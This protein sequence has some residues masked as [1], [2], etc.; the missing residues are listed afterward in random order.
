MEQLSNQVVVEKVADGATSAGTDVN[1]TAVDLQGYDGVMFFAGIATANAGNFLK[2]QEG[3]TTS[4]TADLAGSKTIAAQNGHIVLVDVYRP[5]KRYARP[6]IVRA[7]A[8]TVTGDLYAIKYVGRV[9]PKIAANA[10][11]AL[12]SPIAGT[13]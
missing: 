7:G 13:P 6:V 3:S 10:V 5:L 2:V 1:G 8:N 12:I 11:S 4:P 9:S